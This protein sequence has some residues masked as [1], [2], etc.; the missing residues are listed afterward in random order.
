[1]QRD[2]FER[3]NRATVVT[4]EANGYR[5]VETPDQGCCGALHAHAG[6]LDTARSLARANVAAFSK[7]GADHVCVNA[8]GCGAMMREY[9]ELLEGDALESAAHEVAA[10]VRDATELLARAGPRPGA[11]LR[12]D[13]AY[14]PPCHLLHAQGIA[15]APLRVLDAVPGL[16]RRVVEQAEECCGGAGVY[17][18]THPEL[19]GRIGRDKL[20]ALE[21]SG[22][23]LVVTAN[24]GC[25]MQIAA[26]LLLS[27]R[28]MPV[29]HV[30]EVLAESYRRAAV[31]TGPASSSGPDRE[32][33]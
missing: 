13:V 6:D 1:V 16:V 23:S 17:A 31:A 22:A 20:E 10:G 7:S 32:A 2:L 8:A 29:A 27:G 26:G 5:I 21:A 24:P 9:G 18:M 3:V 19:G 4:L 11:P 28:K 14:D 25:H 12:V 33:P 15:D 30:V